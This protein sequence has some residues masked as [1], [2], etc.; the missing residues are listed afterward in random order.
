MFPEVLLSEQPFLEVRKGAATV[1]KS[2]QI[3]NQLTLGRHLP[4]IVLKCNKEVM[5]VESHYFFNHVL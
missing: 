4:T 5:L 2:R 1:L 3:Q